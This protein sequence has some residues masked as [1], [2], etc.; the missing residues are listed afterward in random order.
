M[1]EGCE[2]RE[3]TKMFIIQMTQNLNLEIRKL[4]LC[5]K[6]KFFL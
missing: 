4:K 6:I 5:F 2:Y 1:E 3:N